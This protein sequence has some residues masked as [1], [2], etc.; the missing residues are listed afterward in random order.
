MH[1]D[2]HAYFCHVRMLSN[3]EFLGKIG[4]SPWLLIPGMHSTRV[5][6]DWL[7]VVDLAL[8]PESAASATQLQPVPGYVHGAGIV[9]HRL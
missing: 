9:I 1:A 2:R 3:D 4:R 5:W 7:H 6:G 8:A